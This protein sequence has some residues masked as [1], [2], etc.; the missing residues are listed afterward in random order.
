MWNLQGKEERNPESGYR[1]RYRLD[2]NG[3]IANR[4]ALTMRAPAGASSD[5]WAMSVG[6]RRGSPWFDFRDKYT[7]GIH[8]STRS[9][10]KQSRL[11][12][13][14]AAWATNLTDRSWPA[15]PLMRLLRAPR[16]DRRI[17][18][19]EVGR[20]DAPCSIP[21]LVDVAPPAMVP[22]T[23]P[24]PMA[25]TRPV[26]PPTSRPGAAPVTTP[27]IWPVQCFC[28]TTSYRLAVV[29]EEHGEHHQYKEM[30]LRFMGQLFFMAYCGPGCARR[31][32][33]LDVVLVAGGYR[34]RRTRSS[35]GPPR[36]RR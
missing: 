17:A 3:T 7:R 35:P 8:A 31:P 26:P 18:K 13:R 16:L 9:T 30:F 20:H 28:C 12:R 27:A 34:Y 25:T 22:S 23:A 10:P 11:E 32:A 5:S 33:V 15:P 36:P 19:T 4:R 1:W 14:R 6:H 29:R 21:Y 24:A 2:D